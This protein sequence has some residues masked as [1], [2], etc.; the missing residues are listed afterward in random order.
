MTATPP[1]VFQR[2]RR[3]SKQNMAAK[4]RHTSSKRTSHSTSAPIALLTDFG[5]DGWYVGAMKG[6]ILSIH[7]TALI[8]DI[9]HDVSAHAVAE[10]ALLLNAVHRCFPVGTIFAAVVDPGVG[11]VREPIV[12][13]ADGRYY[14]APNNGL[15]SLVLRNS[16]EWECRLISNS[17]Y[18]LDDVSSTFHGRDIFA[19]VAAHLARGVPLEEIAPQKT[20]CF[21][22]SVATPS[23]SKE[24][25]E[26][27]IIYF[28]RFGN[29]VT[30]ISRDL[31]E[32]VF[33]R[34]RSK[35]QQTSDT[36]AIRISVGK[37]EFTKIDNTFSDVA[38]GM[39]VVYWGSMGTL[40]IGVNLG[41]AKA[42]LGLNLLD[43]VIIR[44]AI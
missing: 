4:G 42:C 38:P 10:G 44:K 14:I 11:S 21:H 41:N 1:E 12:V 5:W 35:K 2:A 18:F 37:Y 43:R 23:F 3:R 25:L 9:T 40:E 13:R 36:D 24:A 6:V 19:P 34:K 30:N 33:G 22:L 8:V 20:E 31:F 17:K 15:L 29:A 16:K 28:D 32:E 7:P 39:P 26:G 27:H